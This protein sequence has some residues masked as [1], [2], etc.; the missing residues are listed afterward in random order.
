MTPSRAGIVAAIARNTFREAVRDRVLYLLLFFALGLILLSRV[1]SLITVGDE[2]KILKDFGLSAIGLFGVLTAVLMGVG[3]VFKEIERRTVQVILARPI[4]RADFLLGK[5]TGLAAVHLLNTA[6]MT[7]GLYAMLALHGAADPGLL[8]GIGLLY[9]E[10]L[11]MTAAALLFS[12]F[13]TPI[14]SSLLTLGLYA[15]GHLSWSLL[16]LEEKLPPGAGRAVSHA[17]YWLLPNLDRLDIKAEVVHQVAL[18]PSFVAFAAI[19]G[20]GWVLVLLA[21]A[22]AVFSRR[23]FV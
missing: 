12:S 11:V 18:A 14:L 17:F 23:E 22:C 13:S 4:R 16:L 1:L 6:A 8:R 10:Q 2:M 5:F 21:A 19:Y 7:L 3:L 9:V 20:A 15:V